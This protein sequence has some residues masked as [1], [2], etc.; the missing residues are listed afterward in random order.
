MLKPTDILKM[1]NFILINMG[2][3]TGLRLA[4][5]TIWGPLGAVLE[6]VH[7]AK[8][9]HCYDGDI[10]KLTNFIMINMGVITSPKFAI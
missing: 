5:W 4:I 7:E 9:I 3:T 8:D 6:E 1:T 10:L 2:A